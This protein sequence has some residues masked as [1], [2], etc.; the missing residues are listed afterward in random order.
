[1][2]RLTTTQVRVSSSEGC[3][4][5]GTACIDYDLQEK[6]TSGTKHSRCVDILLQ[7]TESARGRLNEYETVF[8]SVNLKQDAFKTELFSCHGRCITD[9]LFDACIEQNKYWQY[10]SKGIL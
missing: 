1:M 8:M 4:R 7:S 6:R 3:V 5:Q 9:R 10:W 2:R